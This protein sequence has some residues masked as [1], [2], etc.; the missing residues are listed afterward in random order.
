MKFRPHSRSTALAAAGASALLLI[1]ACGGPSAAQST[2]H[3]LIDP[4]LSTE[5]I[6]DL[7]EEAFYW[8]LNIAGYYELRHVFTELEGNRHTAVSTGS[9]HS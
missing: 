8:G 6:A 7:S 3:A 9:S 1:T 5:Q 4:A 2:E